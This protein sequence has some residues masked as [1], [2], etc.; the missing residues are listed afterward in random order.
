MAT[1]I[2]RQA[3]SADLG[4][5]GGWLCRAVHRRGCP[6]GDHRVALPLYEDGAARRRTVACGRLRTGRSMRRV[7]AEASQQ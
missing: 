7:R 3:P 6:A 4:H 1:V 5:D 2:V